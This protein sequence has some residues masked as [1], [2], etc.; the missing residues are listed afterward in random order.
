MR[1]KLLHHRVVDG[2]GGARGKY[3]RV[4]KQVVAD[5]FGTAERCLAGGKHGWL[6]ARHGTQPDARSDHKQTTVPEV[7]F[8]VDIFACD[9]ECGL[10]DEAVQREG[11]WIKCA[12][13]ANAKIA[14]AR[15]WLN[16]H[17]AEGDNRVA[18]I[19]R[20]RLRLRRA[21]RHRDGCMK[22]GEIR[23]GMIGGHHQQ[24]RVDFRRALD[25]EQ[26]GQRQGGRGV[27]SHRLGDELRIGDADFLKLPA[28]HE[29]M[30][31]IADDDRRARSLG[32]KIAKPQRG[33]LQHSDIL[34]HR[35]QL[36]GHVRA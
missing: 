12:G 22:A 2:V 34:M 20:A 33:G 27:A 35:L 21:Q 17:D 14:V 11:A 18:S 4:R 15:R 23:D 19:G 1:S 7:L 13:A 6:K 24:D 30:R 28:R 31:V 9:F 36:F 8:A 29:P 32:R 26:S 10:L 3:R 25:G 16:R 5:F